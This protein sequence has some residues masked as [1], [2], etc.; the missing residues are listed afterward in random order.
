MAVVEADTAPVVVPVVDNRAVG[1]VVVV[2]G[3]AVGC[4]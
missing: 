2:V 4:P 1:V 3:I